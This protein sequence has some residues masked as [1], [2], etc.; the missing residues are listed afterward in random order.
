M[1][2]VDLESLF[3]PLDIN[4]IRLN[5]RFIMPGMNRGWIE[6]GLPS[7][8]YGDYYASRVERGVGLVITG[9]CPV[10]HPSSSALIDPLINERSA[11]AWSRATARVRQAG[12]HIFQQLWHEGAIRQ[13]GKGPY[14]EGPTL[15]PSGLVQTG[16]T[17]G[18]AATVDELAEIT[19]AFADAAVIA[20]NSGFSGVE[21]HGA[22]GYF[23]DQFLWSETNL[24]SDQYGGATLLERATYPLEV[25]RAVRWAVGPDYPIS[26]RFSQ[27]KEVDFDASIMDVA[28]EMGGFVHAL[29]EAGVDLLNCSSRYF[30]K[31][32]VE[33][34]PLNLAG[35]AKQYAS[36][37]VVSVGSLG[38]K[39]D[40][41][42]GFL[43]ENFKFDFA[44]EQQ[45]QILADQFNRGDFDLMAIGRS[46]IGDADW[47]VKVRQGRYREIRPFTKADVMGDYEWDPGLVGEALG[48]SAEA[49]TR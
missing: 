35:W 11:Q 31:P 42:G 5:S 29:E 7:S 47:L 27:W 39:I 8:K 43:A 45:L 34:S 41:F 9:A 1:A 15:S 13:E 28:T 48:L 46:I 44:G 36:V 3:E 49:M 38:L 32:E 17:N 12:G 23:L 16:R 37:P 19:Q 30:W 4:N 6:N 25:I 21:L 24:R 2:Y 22:H 33:G 14:P 18:R 10:D 26:F 40:L 20:K